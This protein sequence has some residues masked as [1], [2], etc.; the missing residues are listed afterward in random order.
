MAQDAFPSTEVYMIRRDVAKRLVVPLGV[1]PGDEPSGFGVQLA[2]EAPFQ[3]A[4][5]R[6]AMSG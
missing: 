4:D 2:P 5:A 3:R 6:C 1:A